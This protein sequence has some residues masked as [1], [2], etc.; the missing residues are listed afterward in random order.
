LDSDFIG[1]LQTGEIANG[2]VTLGK[3]DKMKEFILSIPIEQPDGKIVWKD[4]QPIR[5]RGRFGAEKPLFILK[6]NSL[7]PVGFIQDT[8]T[9]EW[10]NP[11]NPNERMTFTEKSL[12][13]LE[14]KFKDTK[15]L[16]EILGSTWN[17]RFLKSMKTYAGG[18]GGIDMKKFL[19]IIIIV[20]V[21]GI[22]GYVWYYYSQHH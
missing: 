1:T 3:G 2:K 10:V 12:E 21:V 15:L 20:F 14:P 16:P 9:K 18:G 5:L 11:E 13:I 8:K 19:P 22:I 6:W 7:F 17:L 4:V